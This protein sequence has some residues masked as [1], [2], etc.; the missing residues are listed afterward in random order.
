MQSKVAGWLSN[1]ELGEIWPCPDIS[2]VWHLLVG[3]EK[4]RIR[5]SVITADAPPEI[6]RSTPE[7]KFRAFPK[8]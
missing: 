7:D 5:T 4:A 3:T 6:Y 8:D 2:N 1:N